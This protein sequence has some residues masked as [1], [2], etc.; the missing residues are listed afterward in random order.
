MPSGSGGASTPACTSPAHVASYDGVSQTWNDRSG[1]GYNFYRGTTSGGDASDPTFNGAPGD[2]NGAYFS[3]DGGDLF[4]YSTTNAAWMDALHKSG[5][6][7]SVFA[8]Y[9]VPSSGLATVLGTNNGGSATIGL[10]Y[11]VAEA[12]ANST[13]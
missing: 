3:F 11:R 7:F 2:P 5:A 12:S 9:F 4:T 1:G 8:L 13:R 6:A 10:V